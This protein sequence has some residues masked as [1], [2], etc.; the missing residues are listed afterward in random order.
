VLAGSG[1][2]AAAAKFLE[3]AAGPEGQEVLASAGFGP[4]TT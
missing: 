4:G 2:K 1:N 3:F